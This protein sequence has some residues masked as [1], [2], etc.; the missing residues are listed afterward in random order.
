MNR[1]LFPPIPQAD[2]Q[3]LRQAMQAEDDTEPLKLEHL[4]YEVISHI[5]SYVVC[6]GGE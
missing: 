3:I 1:H 4:P 2:W 6:L 5:L